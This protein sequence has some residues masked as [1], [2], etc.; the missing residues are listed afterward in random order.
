LAGNAIA[1]IGDQPYN[2]MHDIISSHSV[3]GE[4]GLGSADTRSVVPWRHDIETG[5]WMGSPG[6]ESMELTVETTTEISWF[7]EIPTL[8]DDSDTEDQDSAENS[9]EDQDRRI[10][11]RA[12]IS[13]DYSHQ[14]N[15]HA[16]K[17]QQD[18]TT[19]I[20]TLLVHADLPGSWWTLAGEHFAQLNNYVPSRS[21]HDEGKLRDLLRVQ[22]GILTTSIPS[23]QAGG[24]LRNGDS[25][26]HGHG[27]ANGH[28]LN[29]GMDGVM[30][31]V[32]NGMSQVENGNGVS[33][34]VK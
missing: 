32:E 24:V 33:D 27:H 16:E 7:D 34:L 9:D 6:D 14:S 3:E 18:I 5:Q 30:G 4:L 11:I 25:H 21:N 28:G 22:N 15:G 13:P 1:S 12:E 20:R 10:G 31:T 8:E 17:A 2:K 19:G 23:G 29:G 26:G